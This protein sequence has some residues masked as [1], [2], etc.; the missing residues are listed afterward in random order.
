[1]KNYYRKCLENLKPYTWQN[2]NQKIAEKYGLDESE[3]IRFD[4]NTMEGAQLTQLPSVGDYPDASYDELITGIANYAK[5]ECS[6]IVAGAGADEIIDMITKIFLEPGDR[7][8]IST[9]TYSMYKICTE[10]AGGKTIEVP[11]ES[12]YSIKVNKLTEAANQNNAKIIFICN[13]NNPDGSLITK[14]DIEKILQGFSGPV[15]VDEAYFEFCNETAIDLLAKYENLIIIRTFSKAFALAGARVGYAIASK[16]V[17]TQI[18]KVRPPAS[19][20]II[21]VQLALQALNNLG[22]MRTRVDT[23]TTERER[24]KSDLEK[25]GF[26]VYPSTTNFLLF[27][28]SDQSDAKRLFE[29]ALQKGYILR[30][31]STKKG[32]ERCLRVTVRTK[33]DND[34]LLNVFSNFPDAII[35]DIDGV[36]VDVSQSYNEAIKQT[37]N[38]FTGKI[39]TPEDIQSIKKLPNSN[40]DW[41]V[42]YA[43]ITGITDLKTIDRNTQDYLKIKN[44]FQ[45]LY[46]GGLMDKEKLLITT[47]TLSQ[48]KT[49]N[50]KLGVVTSRPREEAIYAL[51]SLIKNFF[52]KPYIIALE[53]CDQEKPSPKPLLLAKQRMNCR[54]AI[55]VGDTINDQLAAKAAGM[56]FASVVPDLEADYRLKDVNQILEVLR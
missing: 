56:K 53:D 7:V 52:P 49:Q 45:E 40:N 41:D 19:I 51:R 21:S 16:E 14:Q 9:P 38:E 33:E 1:M 27:R 48:L 46:L 13:P 54:N 31:L 34:K 11:R 32:T 37:V 35:F 18:N 25:L 44:K 43:L 29:K 50:Y 8:I 42:T 24:M 20:S 12:N 26:V 10:I 4:Q 22:V 17:V 39:I 5:V 6:Q 3:I 47:T 2:S 36:L 15:V 28:T 23:I 55:Y 30:N